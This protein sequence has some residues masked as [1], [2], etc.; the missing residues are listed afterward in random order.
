MQGRLSPLIDGKIQA[1]PAAC[2]ED[3][4]PLAAELGFDQIEWTLDHVGL[5]NN[6]LMSR[7][8]RADM[9]RLTRRNKI[10]VTSV[11]MDNVMQAPFHKTKGALQHGL[12][13]DF[14]AVVDACAAAKIKILV[15]P[16][17]DDGALENAEDEAALKSGLDIVFPVLSRNQMRIAFESDFPPDRLAKFLATYG[18]Q[19]FGLTYDIGNS[20]GLG[21][22]P[23]DE[24]KAYG[25]RIIHVH[26]KD[27]LRGGSTVPLGEGDALFDNVFDY[28]AAQN[29]QGDIILQTAR[30]DDDNHG[31]VLTTYR[32]M[33]LDWIADRQSGATTA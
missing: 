15:L 29:Y 21:F 26:V 16:L 11:T 7:E 30:A 4:F 1:F 24:F 6:P 2:W 27:R 9:R 3:E 25:E 8:G 17:V 13:E 10:K 18:A 31:G 32:S 20:A 23:G 28:I 19:N 5:M 33:V 12:L 14:S 22:D